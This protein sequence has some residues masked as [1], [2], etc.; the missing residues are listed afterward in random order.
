[1]IPQSFIQELLARVDIVEVVGRSVKLRKAGANFLGLCP[2]HG[3]KSPSFTVS[4]TKQFY[5]CF[6]CGVH[7]SA[8]GFLMEQAGLG[9]V[10][11]IHE[12][13]RSAGLTVPRSRRRAMLSDVTPTCSRP[14]LL[15]PGST[16]RGFG[17]RVP[18]STI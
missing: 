11:A 10:D 17:R 7:G 1:M 5:H 15:P 9:Y 3:E 18:P 12:L 2:F 6:G 14:W 13:A 16:S 8:V 4:P